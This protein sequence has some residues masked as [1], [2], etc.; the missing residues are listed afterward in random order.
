MS[1]HICV[2]SRLCRVTSV[3]SHCVESRL[4]Q[5]TSVSSHVCVESLPWSE[6]QSTG[7]PS[8]GK[9]VTERTKIEK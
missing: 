3:S 1:S 5:V 6:Y 2:E 9:E 4:C 8:G 7:S